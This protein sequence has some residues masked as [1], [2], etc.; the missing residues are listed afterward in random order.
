MRLRQF[1]MPLLAA[2]LVGLT[3]PA[4][5]AAGGNR[6]TPVGPRIVG[7]Q[8]ATE[9]YPFAAS[10]Q[11]RGGGHF[12]GAALIRPDWLLTAR[13]CVQ[14]DSPSNV[15]A[16][17]GSIDRTSGGT[18]KVAVRIVTHPASASDV[19]VVQLSS[20][21]SYPPVAIAPSVPIGAPIRL[22]GWGATRDPNPGPP[23]AIL[24]QLDTTVLP[25]SRC[26]TGGPQLCVGNV[27]GWRGACYG[28]SGGPAVLRAAG[29]WQLAGTTTGGTS[30]VCGQGPSI[31][32][33]AATHRGW[34]ESVVGGSVPPPTDPPPGGSWAPY[35]AYAVGAVVTYGGTGYRALQ[36][37]TSVPGWE[38]PHTPALWQ[39]L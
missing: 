5:G 24:Q 20:P 22:L 16:R 8:P 15:Q 26:G 36:A 39:P 35:T 31:Y 10:L 18:V 25:D 1:S 38:P 30:A 23:P 9:A 7:G 34:I 29:G 11:S 19:A 2:A 27:D 28:D 13:H 17:I 33:D 37:H 12:C 6:P 3:A 4:A 32:M 14:G 21:V